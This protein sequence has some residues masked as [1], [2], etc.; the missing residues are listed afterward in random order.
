MNASDRKQCPQSEMTC[1]YA[2][3]ALPA[4][5]IAAAEAHI[6]SCPDCQRELEALRPVLDRFVSWPT[7]VLRPSASLQTRLALRIAEETGRQPVPPTPRQR[8]EPEWEQVAPGIECKLLAADI[9]RHRVSMLVRLTPGAS[10]PAHTH[11]GVEELHLL[12]GELWIDERKLSPGDYNYGAPG[13]S[14][15]HVWSETGC[16]CVLVTSTKDMLR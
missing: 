5:E 11:A 2:L 9:E 13:A 12:D 10:Y 4:S 7:D 14:D 15:H 8:V 1:A 3:Q 6:A 16:T